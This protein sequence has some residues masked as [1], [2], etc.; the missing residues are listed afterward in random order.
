MAKKS[1]VVKSSFDCTPGP[2][3]YVI[4]STKKGPMF[5]MK[6]KNQRSQERCGNPSPDQYAPMF[7]ITQPGSMTSRFSKRERFDLGKC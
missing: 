7:H 4:K 3:E 2:G 5:S 6:G 1:H